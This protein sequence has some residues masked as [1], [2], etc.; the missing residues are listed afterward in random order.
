M[1]G[2]KNLLIIGGTGFIGSHVVKEAVGRGFSVLVISKN[3]PS[4]SSRVKNVEYISSNITVKKDPPL[5][6][7]EYKNEENKYEKY[8]KE[9]L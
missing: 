6:H 3:I 4:L 1:T 8:F 5:D 2:N 9:N 7:E